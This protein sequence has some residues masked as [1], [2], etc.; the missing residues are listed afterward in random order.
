MAVNRFPC[1]FAREI[2]RDGHL[3]D[4]EFEAAHHAAEGLDDDRD[5]LEVER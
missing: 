1:A 5:V 4:V 3:G 2:G